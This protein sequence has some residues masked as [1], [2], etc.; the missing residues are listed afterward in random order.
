MFTKFK[1]LARHLGT[2]CFNI[3]LYVGTVLIFVV[4]YEKYKLTTSFSGFKLPTNY[5]RY[6]AHFC[7]FFRKPVYLFIFKKNCF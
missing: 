4:S 2:F 7:L 5:Y 3:L 6:Y 1:H